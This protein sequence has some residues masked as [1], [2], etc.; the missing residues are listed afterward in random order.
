MTLLFVTRKIYTC[1][2]TE[3]GRLA[4]KL[5]YTSVKSAM[6]PALLIDAVWRFLFIH[7]GMDKGPA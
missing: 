7:F 6:Q 5:T 3:V 4:M 1:F 2:N